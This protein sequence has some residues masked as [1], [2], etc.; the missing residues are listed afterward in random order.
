MNNCTAGKLYYNINDNNQ[1]IIQTMPNNTPNNYFCFGWC[2]EDDFESNEYYE[3]RE[4]CCINTCPLCI[5]NCCYCESNCCE[6][7]CNGNCSPIF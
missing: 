3:S 4:E 2:Y 7:C 6:G 1:P 5:C